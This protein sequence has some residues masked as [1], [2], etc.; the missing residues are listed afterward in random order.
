MLKLDAD[1][2][3]ILGETNC[4]D[5][6][7]PRSNKR[8][9]VDKTLSYTNDRHTEEMTYGISFPFIIL[10]NNFFRILKFES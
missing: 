10:M 3:L 9:A 2:I 1:I 7:C 8:V 5:N 4:L 6:Q